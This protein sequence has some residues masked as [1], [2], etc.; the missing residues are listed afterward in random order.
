MFILD[1][2]NKD[3]KYTYKKTVFVYLAVSAFTFVI[4]KVYAI[5]GHGVSSAS[6][7]WA[8]LYPFI[9]GVIFYLLIGLMLPEINRFAGY[10]IMYNSYNSGIA[11]LTVGSI[12]KGVMDI[13]GTSSSYLKLYTIIGYAFIVFGLV[14]LILLAANYKKVCIRK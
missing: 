10:R 12:L 11:V 4:N 1:I 8:F 5:F 14:I 6:M 3:K 9:G 7:T 13:A 2:K